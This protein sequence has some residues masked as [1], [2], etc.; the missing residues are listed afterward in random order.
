MKPNTISPINPNILAWAA[1]VDYRSGWDMAA[2][3][4]SSKI[5]IRDLA[6]WLN[7][8]QN[9][10]RKVRDLGV[11]QFPFLIGL[12]YF[13]A[14]RSIRTLRALAADL[15]RADRKDTSGSEKA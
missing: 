5:A 3:L 9:R 12:E 1:Q 15:Q 8:P 6:L 10:V 7:V 2:A 14:I 13:A 11:A 4:R